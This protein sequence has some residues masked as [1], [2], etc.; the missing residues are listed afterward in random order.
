MPMP[1]AST[2]LTMFVPAIRTFIGDEDHWE[3]SHCKINEKIKVVLDFGKV[4]GYKISADGSSVE[5]SLTPKTDQKSYALLVNHTALMFR[6]SLT[7]DQIFAIENEI[8]ELENGTAFY[9]LG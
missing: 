8:Y 9:R 3:H 6:R 7:K 5:P 4:P 1:N 2:P